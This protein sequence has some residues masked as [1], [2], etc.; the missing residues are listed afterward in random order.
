MN[1]KNIKQLE[2]L[3]TRAIVESKIEFTNQEVNIALINV[4]LKNVESV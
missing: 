2:S 3:I 4:L 1:D